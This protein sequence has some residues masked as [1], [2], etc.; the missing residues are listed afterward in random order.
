M[1]QLEI[2]LDGYG[3]PDG[4]VI[5]ATDPQGSRRWPLDIAGRLPTIDEL[6]AL[7]DRTKY[8]PAI[9]TEAFPDT[10]NDWYWTDTPCAWNTSA[11][12]VVA[13]GDGD[14]YGG[15]RSDL[16]CVR[17]VRSSPAGQ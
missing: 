6:F 2:K 4:N 5:M 16:A 13:F 17:A 7:A 8:A 12:W 10:A 15:P 14:A 3:I 9:D 1:R 11:V